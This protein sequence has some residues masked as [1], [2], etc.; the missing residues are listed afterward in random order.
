[1]MYDIPLPRTADGRRLNVVDATVNLNIMPLS[2]ATM[3]LPD[4][5]S[6]PMRSWVE[7]F[8]SQG[9]A[10]IFRVRSPG[11]SFGQTGNSYQLDHG[12][13]EV[14]DWIIKAEC[15]YD[16]AANTILTSIWSHYGGSKWQLGSI[17]ATERVTYATDYGNVLSAIIDIMGQLPGH[18][19]AFNF[20]TTPWTVSVVARPQTVSGEARLGRNIVSC[21]ISEDDSNLCTRLQCYGNQGTLLQTM[22]ADTQSTYGVVEQV[23][24]QS[25][26]E[27]QADF[28]ATCQKYL[29]Q[30]K[31]PLISI[32]I[33][34]RDLQQIT[35]ESLDGFALG[36]QYR[37]A[38]PDHELTYTQTVC[39]LNWPSVY[40]NPGAVTVTLGNEEIA[41]SGVYSGSG[42]AGSA[43]ASASS[44]KASKQAHDDHI[45]RVE[46]N[47]ILHEA[48]LEWDENH[49]LIF[50]HDSATAIGD[51]YAGINVAAGKI[52]LIAT[53]EDLQQASS[54][55][56]LFQVHSDSITAEVT[57]ATTAEGT[58]GSRIQQTADAITAEVSRAQGAEGQLSSRISV[59][60]DQ[61]ST[62]VTNR[63]NA[64]N[65]MSSRITQNANNISLVVS[66]GGIKAASIVTAINGAGSSVVIS[67]D[68]VDI[69]GYLT[70][71][72]VQV[73]GLS[74]TQ[75]IISQGYVVAGSYVN[76]GQDVQV[77]GHS[78]KPAIA[79]FGA[80]TESGGNISIPT[81]T[82][83]GSNGP[84]INFSI[85]DTQTY[86]NAAVSTVSVSLSGTPGEDAGHYYVGGTA[87]LRTVG[88]TTISKGVT[89]GVIVDSAVA[90]GRNLM[91]LRVSGNT[92][93][94][95][96]S[97]KT[98]V[99]IS[100]D[101]S[102]HYNSTTHK[103]T[104]LSLAYADGVAMTG[105]DDTSAPSGTEAYDA[106]V[107]KGHSDRNVKASA[108]SVG[109][110]TD[111]P[112]VGMVTFNIT[113][114]ADDGTTYTSAYQS[115]SYSGGG[116]Y[117][118]VNYARKGL[119]SYGYVQMYV[120]ERNTYYSAGTHYWYWSSSGGW[121]TLY[122]LSS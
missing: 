103:Y 6:V 42:G 25:E 16:G 96:E 13:V 119:T 9:S 5:E 95:Y 3:T 120:Y 20:T 71:H 114:T 43:A 35:G 50:A 69:N 86:K 93:Q 23:A 12:I 55:K 101:A 47:G 108:F 14:G 110:I 88:G 62:E 57:R 105:T 82:V 72:V 31:N 118:L 52:D 38:L 44:K 111:Y 26:K 45:K 40:Q 113:A 78:L 68:K 94:R 11:K 17:A 24:G 19:L 8:T 65:Q 29:D 122:E 97:S 30:H 60:A 79:E 67:A 109:N 53:E 102:V 112:S 49:V 100:T 64:D 10:G 92:I 107:T 15:D 115:I 117:T 22:N 80:A 106:G 61:I 90:Y 121:D 51:M 4:N 21:K 116:N 39:T 104:A 84:P 89:G 41:V 85:T 83:M 75:N 66:D 33:D 7:M 87:T 28:L 58:M 18:M 54:S 70:A 77:S 1:M 73:G 81:K 56:S 2:T 74:S 37:V 34:L 36:S 27:A 76:A 59:T 46:I 63:Q 91:G 99:T 98:S 32:S 48:G